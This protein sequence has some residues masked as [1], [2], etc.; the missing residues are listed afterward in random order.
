MTKHI[1]YLSLALFLISSIL[2]TG[3]VAQSARDNDYD[4]AVQ[5]TGPFGGD[6]T[7]MA[8]DPRSADRI[9][10]GA[11]DGQIFRSTDGGRGWTRIRPGV[12]APGSAV[13]VIML[14]SQKPGVIY[15]GMK[16]LLDLN[17]EAEGG[18]VFVSED[19]GQSWSLF[20]GMRGRSVR[21]M[22]QSAKDP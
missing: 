19:D 13:T 20:E 16:P 11:S 22:S 15:V 14:D 3:S 17:E 7:A 9:W 8:I 4:R 2:L 18:G 10:I 12:K 1:K 6:A 21:A 5:M